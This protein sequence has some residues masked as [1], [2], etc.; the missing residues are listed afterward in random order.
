[1]YPQV[2]S[3]GS[4]LAFGDVGYRDAL[5]SFMTH[6]VLDAHMF[7]DDGAVLM[8]DVGELVITAEQIRSYE[9]PEVLEA[10]EDTIFASEPPSKQASA[11]GSGSLAL[12]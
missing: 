10:D 7:R 1:M 3:D 8:F 12:R 4:D 2:R 6:T 5:C 11:E 9:W